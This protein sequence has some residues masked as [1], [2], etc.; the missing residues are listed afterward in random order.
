MLVLQR[1]IGNTVLLFNSKMEQVGE[2]KFLRYLGNGIIKIGFDL[3]KDITILREEILTN[4]RKPRGKNT[5]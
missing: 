5:E 1:K 2:V 4:K 3:P